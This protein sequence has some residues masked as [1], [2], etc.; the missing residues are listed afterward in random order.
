LRE[1]RPGQE[2]LAERETRIQYLQVVRSPDSQAGARTELKIN[3]GLDS[4]H[5]VAV[6][7]TVFTGGGYYDWHA[8]V[9][10]LAGDGARPTGLRALSIG[11]AAGTFRRIYDAVHPGAIV[12]AVELDPEAV[13][14]GDRFFGSRRAPGKVFTALD[15]RVFVDRATEQWHVIH[16]DAYGHQVYIPAHLA[17][18]EFFRAAFQ[19]LLPGGVIACNVG[20]LDERDPVLRAIAATMAN[21]FGQALAFHV[22]DSRNLLLLARRDRLVDPTVLAKVQLGEERL[23]ASDRSIWQG[24][25]ARAASTAAWHSFAS[26]GSS[27]VD[28]CPELD[29]LLHQSYVASGDNQVLTTMAGDQ[30]VEAAEAAAH[31]ARLQADPRAV[32]AAAQASSSPSAY[33]RLL[34]GDARWQL[35]ELRG[36]QAEYAAGIGLGGDAAVQAQ[37]R[38]RQADLAADLGPQASAEE[39]ATRNGWLGLIAVALLMLSGWGLTRLPHRRF[40]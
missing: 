17:S 40:A 14:L 20:G 32:L 13:R 23:E 31:Q 30:R 15:G 12:D 7:G 11:D 25:L 19:R 39:V 2:L 27:L 5:S 10:F 16:V 9:P 18:V 22:P 38:Q 34:V 24:L 3:E 35:R 4:F 28:D 29:R 21:V 36:A 8:L 1:V 26:G 37:L 33:L 6:E